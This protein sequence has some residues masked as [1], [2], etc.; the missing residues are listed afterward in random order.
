MPRSIS[1]ASKA[2]ELPSPEAEYISPRFFFTA[3]L[4]YHPDRAV[5][6]RKVE[7]SITAEISQSAIENSS[8]PSAARKLNAKYFKATS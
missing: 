4:G 7:V 1:A 5:P 8:L 2:T 3:L 6:H